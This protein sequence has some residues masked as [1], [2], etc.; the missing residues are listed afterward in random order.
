MAKPP[1]NQN[2]PPLRPRSTTFKPLSTG[3]LPELEAKLNEALTPFVDNHKREQIIDRVTNVIVE[4]RFSGPLPHP[5]ILASY[6][7]ICPGCAD[8]IVKMAETAQIRSEDRKD[9]L[10]TYEYQDRKLGLILGFS[11]VV[12]TLI[13]G[14]TAALIAAAYNH[15]NLAFGFGGLS[16]LGLIAGVFVQGRKQNPPKPDNP[17]E[18]N[19]SNAPKSDINP[20]KKTA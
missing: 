14:V 1:R 19:K 18:P 8:R 10:I 2:N 9:K 17:K 7:Q 11:A 6:E 15:T 5:N 4:Q 12:I 13:A 16:V 3:P 20:K